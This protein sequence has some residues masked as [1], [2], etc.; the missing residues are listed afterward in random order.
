MVPSGDDLR[1][2]AD[3]QGP[4]LERIGNAN[5]S[6]M[7]SSLTRTVS[8]SAGHHYSR[9]EWSSAENER[10]FGAS[11]FRHGHN[12][13]LAVTVTGPIDGSTGF[14]TDLGLLD[15]ALGVLVADLD[16]RDLTEVIPEFAPGQEIPTTE[17]LAR[18]FWQRLSGQIPGPG[19]LTCV[20]VAESD[21][22]WAE[23]SE[24][25]PQP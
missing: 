19:R 14:V 1:S 8:F 11:R 16:Q 20:R 2:L 18:W 12:Y 6:A 5:K 4:E 9:P 17:S 7:P 3:A 10:V 21:T 25:G 23:Y 13:T 22:L 15:A 24:E